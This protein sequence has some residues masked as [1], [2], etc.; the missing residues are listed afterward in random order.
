M[1]KKSWW[2][3]FRFN[4]MRYRKRSPENT[5][6]GALAYEATLKYKLGRG[7]QIDRVA[8]PGD[9]NQTFEAFAE[10]WFD[11]YVT[12]NNKF[13]EARIKKYTLNSSL[14]PFFGRIPI[15]DIKAYHIGQFK[16]RKVK[17]GLANKTIKNHLTVFNKCRYY[18]GCAG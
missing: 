17:D 16:A 18:P 5:R 4:H 14:I 12:P 1:D 13:S 2:V 3:D 11:E 8:T 9:Q 10:R 7:E 6:I 15:R